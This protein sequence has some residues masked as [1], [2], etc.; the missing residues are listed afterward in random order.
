MHCK[1]FESFKFNIISV[2]LK[3]TP[4]WLLGAASETARKAR[5]KKVNATMDF[6]FAKLM[7]LRFSKLTLFI[8]ENVYLL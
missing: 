7:K 5:A 6:I 1:I 8:I 4:H 3:L 2:S